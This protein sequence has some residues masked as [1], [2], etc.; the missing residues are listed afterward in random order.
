MVII[1]LLIRLGCRLQKD[2][3]QS[4]NLRIT[5]DFNL[6]QINFLDV[7]MKIKTAKYWPYRKPNDNPLYP[8]GGLH[9]L[10]LFT[11]LLSAFRLCPSSEYLDPLCLFVYVFV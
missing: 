1:G 8:A 10:N 9:W 7:T 6:T 4:L 11:Y 2:L 3:F 5:C